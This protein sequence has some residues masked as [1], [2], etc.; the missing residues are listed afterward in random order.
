MK[1]AVFGGTFNPLHVGHAMLAE[2]VV[3]EL[4]YEKLLF[5]PTFIPPHKQAGG[6]V[7]A[8]HRL[9]MIERFCSFSADSEKQHFFAESC[10]IER[11]GISYTS[12]T[13]QFIAEKY[14]D[15]LDGDRLAF[16]M[17]QEVAAQ[18]YKW[19]NPE[20]VSALADLL[21]ASRVP[22]KNGVETAGTENK[23]I[24]LYTEDYADQ[25]YV[26]NFPYP[27]K[28]VGNPIFP[29]SSTEIRARIAN[30]KAWRYLVPEPVFQY[31]ISNSLYGK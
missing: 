31:I 25:S 12:E 10:E 14:K 11:G 9:E 15:E 23:P 8:Q 18:F 28:F 24:G 2:T 6:L 17:G 21:I 7:S 22:E 29:V 4:G 1:I 5:V 26:E 3:R 30:G 20:Q 27:H 19:K 13:L 16:V